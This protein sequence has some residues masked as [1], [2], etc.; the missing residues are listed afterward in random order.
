[1]DIPK[2]SVTLYKPWLDE[3]PL[4]SLLVGYFAHINH[5][6]REEFVPSSFIRIPMVILGTLASFLIFLITK[7]LSGFWT[8]VLAMIIYGITPIMVFGSRTALPENLIAVSL[9]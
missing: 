2:A 4:F 7:K 6:N 3:P 8:G 1:G 5:A 9:L